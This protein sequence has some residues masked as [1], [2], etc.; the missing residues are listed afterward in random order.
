M[1]KMHIFNKY[2]RILFQHKVL[3][4]PVYIISF[5]VVI[6]IVA[7]LISNDKPLFCIYN[8]NWLFPTFSAKN[9]IIVQTN[10]GQETLNYNMGKEWKLLETSFAIFPLCAYSPNTIDADNAPLKSPFDKQVITLK[11]GNS[12]SLP[13]KYRHWLGTT[14]NGNDVL[15]GI[16]H[17]TKISISVGFFSMLLAALIGISLGAMAGY[18]QNSFFKVGYFQAV[19]IFM[20]IFFSWFYGFKVRSHALSNAL[21]AGSGNMLLQLLISLFIISL[22]ML[23]FVFIGK[24]IDRLFKLNEKVISIPIDLIIS[25]S[26][27]VLNSIPSLLLVITLAS[28]LTP[29]YI[30]LILII[31]FL[32]WTHLARLVRAEYLKA[33]NFDYVTAGKA[34]GFSDLQIII[35]HILPN[36]FPVI[37]VQL[38]F[39]MAG[40][41][42]VESSLSFIGVGV[43]L[44]VA[45]WGSLLNEARNNFSAWWLVLFPGLCLFGL[46]FS[47]NKIASYLSLHQ[48]E[49]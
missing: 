45:T 35:K 12:V 46:V 26:I 40:A 34:L 41:V 2:R 5:F 36:V 23:V 37:L 6:A 43:P 17:G 47:Y 28:I 27:E 25:R 33:K 7:P 14:Q 16:L 39:G 3:K 15:A 8:G 49:D 21:S 48:K 31:G 9:T 24:K 30:S 42:L 1:I 38:V 13:Y 10:F 4:W 29:S 19:F 20:G 18:F 11:N 32:S 44:D 22:V